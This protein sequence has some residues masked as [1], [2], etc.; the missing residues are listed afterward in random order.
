MMTACTK[1][2]NASCGIFQSGSGWN[3]IFDLENSQLTITQRTCLVTFSLFSPRLGFFPLVKSRE[4]FLQFCVDHR[5]QNSGI[6]EFQISTLLTTPELR[7][8]FTSQG[9]VFSFFWGGPRVNKIHNTLFCCHL[10]SEQRNER[11]R[12]CQHFPPPGYSS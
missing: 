6:K 2:S 4:T 9:R 5:N 8:A 10:A 3:F 7:E 1:P 12:S 11:L